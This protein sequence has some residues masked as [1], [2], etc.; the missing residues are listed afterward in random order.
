VIN[1]YLDDERPAPD[2]WVLAKTVDEAKALLLQGV[3]QQASLDHDLGACSDCMGERTPE[4]WL[5]ETKYTQRPN[6]EHFGTGYTLVCWMEETGNWPKERP[7]VH[8]A[9]P[10]GRAKM[11]AAINRHWAGQY[12]TY[13]KDHTRR[14][15]CVCCVCKPWG[16]P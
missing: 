16:T 15:D 11:Q 6:C 14:A 8:S 3:V 9:N 7:A 2:G 5:A 1:M 10:A 13:P 4:D 12:S